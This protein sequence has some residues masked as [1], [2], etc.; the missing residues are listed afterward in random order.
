MFEVEGDLRDRRHHTQTH[1]VADFIA[2][3]EVA[4]DEQEAEQR[5]RQ[6]ADIAH[7]AVEGEG[8]GLGFKNDDAAVD[9]M[10]ADMVDDHRHHGEHL[11]HA[12]AETLHFFGKNG[13]LSYHIR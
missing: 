1:A 2:R 9:Q 10:R 7:E 8:I 3:V 4:L 12:A 13:I 11:E 6:P 5:E